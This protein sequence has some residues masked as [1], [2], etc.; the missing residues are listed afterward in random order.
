[1]AEMTSL[2]SF[3]RRGF[4]AGAAALTAAGMLTGCGREDSEDAREGTSD[5]QLYA[6]CCRGNCFGG[7]YL[8]VHV[9]DGQIVRTTAADMP[10]PQYNRMCSKGATHVGRLYSANR[11]QYPMRRVGERG[12]GEFERISWDEAI[13]EIA[14]KWKSLTDEYGPEAMA[15][16]CISGNF[17]FVS[18]IAGVAW[19]RFK[20]IMGCS[21]I[22]PCVDVAMGLAASIAVGGSLWAQQNEP[23][24]FVNSTSVVCWGSNPVVSQPHN[25]HFFMEA[26]EQGTR[27]VVIDPVFNANAAKADMF[28]PINATTD[29]ALALG[30]INEVIENG[31]EDVEFLRLHTEAPFLI[32]EDGS[33]LKMSDLGVEPTEGEPD[34][35][36]G[37]PTVI[38]PYAVWDEEANAA[39][40]VSSAVKPAITG[41]TEVEGIAVKTTLDNLK[42]IASE[43]T[44]DKVTE[45][46]GVSAE[47]VKEL[48]RIYTQEGPVNTYACFGNDHYV[49]GHYTC[50]CLYALAFVTGQIGKSGAACGLHNI[51]VTGF[52][53]IA[54]TYYATDAQG[55]PC[56]GVGRSVNSN[57]ISEVIDTGKYGDQDITIKGVYI[58]GGNPMTTNIEQNYT[59]EWMSKLDFIVVA[60]NSMTDTAKWADIILPV[61][62]WFEQVDL[63]ALCGTHPYLVWND[64]AT[65]PMFECKSDFEILRLLCEKMGYAEEYA[66]KTEEEALE[67]FFDSDALREMGITFDQMKQDKVARILPEGTYVSF[68]GGEFTTSTGRGRFYQETPVVNYDIGQEIDLS[69]ER[70]PHYE[71]AREAYKGSEV[72][73]KFPYHVISDHMR[74]RTHTQWWD[75]QCLR[76]LDT[77]PCVRISPEDAGEI[78]VTTGDVVRMYN[79]RGSVTLKVAVNAGLPKGTVTSPR[80]YQA[81]E[82]IDGHFSSLGSNGFNQAIANQVFND[83]AVAIEKA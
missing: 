29:G 25:M 53:N 35:T 18:G 9:R 40:E 4:I 64:K 38:D 1:M 33:L 78:G 75:V 42:E 15:T 59:K 69:K 83:V 52:F 47:Q 58:M 2:R 48:A 8:N 10:D 51:S 77:E 76:E 36:T 65:E 63:Y 22:N 20:N 21:V 74:T 41:V 27:Y 17:G 62:H 14:S 60:D 30:V 23:T 49:N 19:S 54:G 46:T 55:N 3:S 7:C 79:D 50:W 68:E 39:V 5:T 57:M 26:K 28:V 70:A 71:H 43:W 34:P 32:K 73:E 13:D 67:D 37:E 56:Q 11:L 44:I 80:G 81:E 31:W 66:W 6:G 72:R 24:D 45:L 16:E 82:Y 61:A 12:A